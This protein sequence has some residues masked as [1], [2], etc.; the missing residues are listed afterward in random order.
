MIWEFKSKSIV[1]LC[2]IVKDNQ[3]TSYPYWPTRE[4]ET[5]KYGNILVTLQSKTA[6]GD[7]SVRMF[8]LQEDEVCGTLCG[9]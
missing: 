6:Y 4:D 5:I 2:N 9:I 7:Y 8:N 1:M 3:E